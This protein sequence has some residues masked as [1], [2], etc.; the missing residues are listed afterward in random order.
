VDV[1]AAPFAVLAMTCTRTVW[2]ACDESLGS[3]TSVGVS[4]YVVAV[5]PVIGWQFAP[6][7]SQRIHWYPNVSG[8]GGLSH[9]LDVD[10]VVVRVCP[11]VGVPAT[12]GSTVLC[13]AMTGVCAESPVA[14]VFADAPAEAETSA[15]NVEPTSAAVA[16]YDLLVAL[17]IAAQPV[18][19]AAQRFHT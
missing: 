17:A 6:D 16:V 5:A 10:A 7:P 14:G 4:T 12:T 8:A 13:G 18:P 19:S 15:F 11:S 2:R 1:D 3:A 9:E